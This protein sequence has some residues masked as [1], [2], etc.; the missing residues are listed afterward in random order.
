MT[1]DPPLLL[2]GSP[3][4]SS[5]TKV[6]LMDPISSRVALL[7]SSSTHSEEPGLQMLPLESVEPFPRRFLAGFLRL[8]ILEQSRHQLWFL[9]RVNQH[10]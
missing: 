3:S 9:Q 10:L 1:S 4:L 6:L 2:L 7:W 5:W 8:A